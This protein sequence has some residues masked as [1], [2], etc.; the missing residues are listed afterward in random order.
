VNRPQ[1]QV[2]GHKISDPEKN[3]EHTFRTSRT[4]LRDKG[5]SW[6]ILQDHKKWTP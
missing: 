6:K 5:L 4:G 2:K 1:F 3:P